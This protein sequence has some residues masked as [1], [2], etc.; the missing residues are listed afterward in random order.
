M[1]TMI[2][3]VKASVA[4]TGT[5]QMQGYIGGSAANLGPVRI[6]SVNAQADAADLEIKIYDGTAATDTLVA[7]L[8]GCSADNESFNFSFGGNG[9]KCGTSAYVVLANCDHFVAYYG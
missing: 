5:G 7:H 4:L 3:D 6:V 9:V 8:K 1:G 2:S